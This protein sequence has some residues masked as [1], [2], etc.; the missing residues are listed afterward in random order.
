MK[1]FNKTYCVILCILLFFSLCYPAL[2]DTTTVY[3]PGYRVK[4]SLD[5]DHN[6]Y[7]AIMATI[8]LPQAA[9]VRGVKETGAAYN[10]LGL[11]TFG[12]HIIEIGLHKDYY[13]LANGKWSVFAYANYPG[14]FVN[15]G[16]NER[17]HNFR[18]MPWSPQGPD[19]VFPDG[20]KVTMILK[21]T[22]KDEVSFAIPG[23]DPILLKVPGADPTG[24]DQIFRRVTSIMTD[25][26]QGFTKNN[27]WE[28]VKLQKPNQD[29]ITW[30]PQPG[31]TLKSNNMDQNDPNGSS[32]TVKAAQYY[33][34]IVDI[35]ELKPM[36]RTKKAVVKFIV[37]QNS[38]TVDDSII[39]MDA[40]T[41]TDQDRTFVPVR[42]LAQALGVSDINWNGDTQTVTLTKGEEVVVL[43]VGKQ[44]MVS[45]AGTV[46]MDVSP[47]SR[48]DRV[49]LPA[50]YVAEAFGY[51]ASWDEETRTVTIQ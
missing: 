35:S 51:Y 32:I 18:I 9:D 20:S 40:T 30:V 38:F 36:Q 2:A 6:G 7:Q 39:E 43:T 34:E 29:F 26:A 3:S 46:S 12:G 33:P 31:E 24:K 4:S 10:Y 44:E 21:V 15:Y 8:T 13:D 27:C 25:D 11:E 19:L 37:G 14:A 48:A 47:V 49:Y 17:W 22:D 42:Y 5:E 50:R 1:Y 41:Y 23:F 16:S 45:P 28:E